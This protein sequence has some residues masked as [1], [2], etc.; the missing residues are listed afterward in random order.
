[1]RISLCPMQEGPKSRNEG[2]A[3]LSIIERERERESKLGAPCRLIH[4]DSLAWLLIQKYFSCV[5]H[6]RHCLTIQLAK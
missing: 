5:A 3:H 2:D 6:Q 4:T 1:M